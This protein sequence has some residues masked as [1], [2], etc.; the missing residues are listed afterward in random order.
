MHTCTVIVGNNA[1]DGEIEIAL[2]LPCD[3]EFMCVVSDFSTKEFRCYCPPNHVLAADGL[4][5]VGQYKFSFQPNLQ[6][7]VQL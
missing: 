4:H 5:C 2:V 1:G 6:S 7:S 3:C